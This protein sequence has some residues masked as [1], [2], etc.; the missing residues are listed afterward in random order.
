MGFE[1]F[2]DYDFNGQSDV[3]MLGHPRG[4]AMVK[5]DEGVILGKDVKMAKYDGSRY[6]VSL[7]SFKGNSGSPVIDKATNKV[8]GLFVASPPD[9][10]EGRHH[11]ITDVKSVKSMFI[12]AGQ[13][14]KWTLENG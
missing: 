13:I 1:L 8:I 9:F 5:H 10:E 6:R 7:S 14:R 3:Y 4:G 12:S 2:E 11:T